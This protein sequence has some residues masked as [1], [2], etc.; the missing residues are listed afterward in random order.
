MK[1]FAAGMQETARFIWNCCESSPNFNSRCDKM[2]LESRKLQWVGLHLLHF[3]NAM[4]KRAH[5]LAISIYMTLCCP[6]SQRL[7]LS[8]VRREHK[9]R[10]EESTAIEEWPLLSLLLIFTFMAHSLT[11]YW[12]HLSGLSLLNFIAKRSERDITHMIFIHF[13]SLLMSLAVLLFF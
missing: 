8:G 5:S 13:S 1:R 10:P 4:W 2:P 11:A 7:G 12:N 9:R 6:E 3:I